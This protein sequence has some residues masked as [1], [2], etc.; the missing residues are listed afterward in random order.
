MQCENMSY[1]FG[2]VGA[3]SGSGG[4]GYGAYKMISIALE[5]INHPSGLKNAEVYQGALFLGGALFAVSAVGLGVLGVGIFSL[6]R[7][8]T[9]SNNSGIALELIS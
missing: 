6:S 1:L 4:L 7:S 3:F 5:M 8:A 2:M 9:P